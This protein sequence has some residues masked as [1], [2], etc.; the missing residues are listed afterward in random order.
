MYYWRERTGKG[1][2]RD[3]GED[4]EAVQG[5]RGEARRVVAVEMG[6]DSEDVRDV[7]G[8]G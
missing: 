7:C 3:Y 1:R 2:R 4:G 5:P 6:C 8:G